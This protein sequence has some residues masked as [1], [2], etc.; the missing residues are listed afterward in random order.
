MVFIGFILVSINGLASEAKA[1]SASLY[2]SPAGGTFIVGDNFSV[3]VKVDTGGAAINAAETSLSFASDLDDLEVVSISKANSIFT[4]WTQDPIFSNSAGT[5]NFGGGVPN[6]GFTGASGTILTIVFKVKSAGT[7]T[8]NFASG[9]VLAND[10]KGTNILSSMSG[11]NYSFAPK[12]TVPT[13]VP[14]PAEKPPAEKPTISPTPSG[15]APS[16][17]TITSTTHPD[18]NKWYKDANPKFSWSLPADVTGVSFKL[19]EQPTSDPGSI[20][21]GLL[22]EKGF[23][24]IPEGISYFHI[25]FQNKYGWGRITHRKVLIDITPPKPFEIKIE[26]ENETDPRPVLHFETVDETSGI[27][28]YEIKIGEGETFPVNTEE[29]KHNPYKMPL[30]AP[31]R[32]TVFVKAYDKAGNSTLASIEVVIKPIKA[33]EITEIPQILSSGEPLSIK[34]KAYPETT[35]VIY[36]QK[37]G[38]EPVKNETKTDKEGNWTYLHDETLKNGIYKIWTETRDA[39]GARSYPSKT[40]TMEVRLPTFIKVGKMVIDYLSIMITLIILIAFFI[41]IA[42]FAWYRISYLRR[43]LK[44]ETREAGESLQK[45]FDN[46]RKKVEEQIEDLDHRPGLSKEEKRIRDNLRDA[47]DTAE[48]TIGKEIKD[49]GKELE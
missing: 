27:E 5:I 39:R 3:A 30:Q 19:D 36:V 28:Y 34:G 38:E 26:R 13:P 46:V 6:P 21:Q 9:A 23:K 40:F 44:K 33:P 2:L 45:A 15:L 12:S 35:I 18:E 48:E 24:D 32:H 42:I 47:L 16:A 31:G 14:T 22:K 43:R 37:E 20:S 8:L 17:P 29:L 41:A 25:K 11:G 4:V 1:A 7:A 10:G 49:I